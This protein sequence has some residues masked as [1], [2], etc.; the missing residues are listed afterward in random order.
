M[1][2]VSG[3]SLSMQLSMCCMLVAGSGKTAAFAL[4]ILERL[5]YRPKRVAAIYALVVTPT[6]ELA[7][8]V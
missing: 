5:L 2:H 6:R 4:P 7:V 3:S 8:Q 1:R